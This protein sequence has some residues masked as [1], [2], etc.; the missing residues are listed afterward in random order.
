MTGN[1]RNWQHFL[2]LRKDGHAQ[3]E[4][5]VVARRVE[6][7]LREIWPESMKVLMDE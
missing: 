3:E 4:V 2:K 7:K 1:L 5:Q 6:E